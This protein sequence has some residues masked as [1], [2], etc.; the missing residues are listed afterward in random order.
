MWPQ[1]AQHNTMDN[2]ILSHRLQ[3]WSSLCLVT[4]IALPTILMHNVMHYCQGKS[5]P[6]VFLKQ[7]EDFHFRNVDFPVLLVSFFLSGAS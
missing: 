2:F 4:A 1:M 5:Q 3:Q 6:E 7:D